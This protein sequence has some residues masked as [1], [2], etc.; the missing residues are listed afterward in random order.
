MQGKAV[1]WTG[2]WSKGMDRWES[3][4][5]TEHKRQNTGDGHMGIQSISFNFAAC[6]KIFPK[7]MLKAIFK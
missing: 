7:K 5:A 4:K 2:E 3:N 1:R 6:L